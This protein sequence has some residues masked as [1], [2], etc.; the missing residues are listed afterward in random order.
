MTGYLGFSIMCV[1]AIILS[2]LAVLIA[3]PSEAAQAPYFIIPGCIA[4]VAGYLAFTAGRGKE[5][6]FER[7]KDSVLVILFWTCAILLCALP[8]RLSGLLD[9]TRA[10]FESASGWSTTGLSTVDVAT[11]PKIFLMYRS[12]LLFFGGVG[13]VLV[14]STVLSGSGGMRLY[15]AEGHSDRLV[16]NLIESARIILVIYSGYIASGTVLYRIFGMG[17]FDA[18]N[19][20]IAAVSTGGFST[21]VESIGYY[22]SVPIEAITVVLMILGNTGFLAHLHLMRG[23]LREFLG[24][25]EMRFFLLLLAMCIPVA[26]FFLVNGLSYGAGEGLRV[27]VFQVVSALTTTG[28]QTVESFTVWSPPLLFLLCLLMLIG[29]GIGSTAGGIKQYRVHALLKTVIWS[30]RD[31][32]SFAGTLHHDKVRRPGSDET[33]NYRVKTNIASFVALYLFVYCAGVFGLTALGAG[34]PGAMFEFASA[35]GT[36]GLSYGIMTADAHPAILWIGTAGMVLGRLEIFVLLTALY[37][38]GNDGV[39]MLGGWRKAAGN[40]TQK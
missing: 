1:G 11:A 7:Q 27:A 28:F 32:F 2:P 38:I 22:R 17:W 31:S 36:V 3:Y 35:L 23:K 40:G 6:M 34:I 30:I 25:G 9:F 16:P 12:I 33:M 26:A 4:L 20:S 21:R 8:F 19:H 10:V 14:M 39:S 18:L 13:I 29:G 5:T 15:S 24:Y 37:R